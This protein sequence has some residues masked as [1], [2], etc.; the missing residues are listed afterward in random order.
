MKFQ[1]LKILKIEQFLKLL[2]YF[3]LCGHLGYY[4]VNRVL[5]DFILIYILLFKSYLTYLTLNQCLL[6]HQVAF[7]NRVRVSTNFDVFLNVF[8]SALI[9]AYRRLR[10]RVGRSIS[11]SNAFCVPSHA[12][13]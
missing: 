12:C 5:S 6:L 11:T 9:V 7:Q 1:A 3:Y 8:Y 10:C 13:L 4:A 2:L